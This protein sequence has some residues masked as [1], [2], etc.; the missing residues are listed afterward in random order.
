M[1]DPSVVKVKCSKRFLCWLRAAPWR[2]FRLWLHEQADAFV[3]SKRGMIARHALLTLTDAAL[4]VGCLHFWACA[5]QMR[6]R[7]AFLEPLDC[8]VA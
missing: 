3:Q 5:C 4:F 6:L 1:L 8:F 7:Y 2:R